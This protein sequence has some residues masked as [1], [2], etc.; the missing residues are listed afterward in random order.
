MRR[1]IDQIVVDNFRIFDFNHDIFVSLRI[2]SEDPVIN[3]I[4]VPASA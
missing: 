1:K 4:P 3:L 2:N